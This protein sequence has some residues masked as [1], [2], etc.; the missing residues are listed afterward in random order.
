VKNGDINDAFE[1]IILKKFSLIDLLQNSSQSAQTNERPLFMMNFLK[2]RYGKEKFNNLIN[3]IE[4]SNNPMTLL[5][6]ES[7]IKAI[8]GEDYA[9]AIKFLRYVMKAIQTNQKI[10]PRTR[11]DSDI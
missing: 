10:L 8:V 3:K 7:Q 11:S 1:G 9:L 2:E 5:E 6:D 4:E